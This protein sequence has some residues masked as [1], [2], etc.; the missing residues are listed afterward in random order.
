[1]ERYNTIKDIAR[2]VYDTVVTGTLALHNAFDI[3]N[4]LQRYADKHGQSSIVRGVNEIETNIDSNRMKGKIADVRSY[5]ASLES[6]YD[7][8]DLRVD[9]DG[10][11]CFVAIKQMPETD[12]EW[13]ERLWKY[14]APLLGAKDNTNSGVR[15]KRY[16]DWKK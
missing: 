10:D 9:D 12:S 7:S 15:V 1:M 4:A 16:S 14:I 11:E 2:L 3:E 8:I 5:L 13:A 6:K